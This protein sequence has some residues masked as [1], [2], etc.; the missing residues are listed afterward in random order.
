MSDPIQEQA[1]YPLK[2]PPPCLDSDDTDSG[3]AQDCP[4]KKRHASEIHAVEVGSHEEHTDNRR[5]S[6]TLCSEVT[7]PGDVETVPGES[8]GLGSGP[9]IPVDTAFMQISEN[10]IICGTSVFSQLP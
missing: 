9:H 5:S 2:R 7:S 8:Q 6:V 1:P 3:A 4:K 10:T